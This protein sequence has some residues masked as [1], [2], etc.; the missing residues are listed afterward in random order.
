MP[1]ADA[2]QFTRLKK[3]LAVQKAEN[4]L[5]GKSVNRMTQFV[6][7]LSGANNRALNGSNNAFL[8]SVT[9]KKS[10][11]RVNTLFN[12]DFAGKKMGFTQNCS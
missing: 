3:A 10:I 6:P 11:P 7:R 4:R 9:L 12:T 8:A 2:S 5:D 1:T